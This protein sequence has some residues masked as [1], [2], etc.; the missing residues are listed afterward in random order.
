MKYDVRFSCGHTE[1]VVL[2]GKTSEREKKIEWYESKAVCSD[3]YREMKNIEA[4]IGCQEI[5]M[6]YREYKEKYARCK[7]KAGSWNPVEKTIVVYVPEN[8]I[9]E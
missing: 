9:A 3:C 7:T 2:Y 4:S 8:M 1:T 5:T 6:M